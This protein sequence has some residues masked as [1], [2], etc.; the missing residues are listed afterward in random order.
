M[1][2]H[3]PP[4]VTAKQPRILVVRN[5]KIGDFMLAWPTLALLR[6]SLPQAHISVLVPAYTQA[7]AQQCPWVD[8][9]LSDPDDLGHINRHNFDAMLTLFSTARTGWAGLRGR[10]PVRVAPAT[11][12]FQFLHNRRLV[13]RRS[14]SLKPEYE[15]NLDLARH[16]LAL[17]GVQPAD[18]PPPFW[19]VS[20]AV[21]E[22]CRQRLI[23]GLGLPADVPWLF[24]HAGSGGSAVNLD[25]SQYE[26]LIRTISQIWPDDDAPA[27]VL[28]AGPG[29]QAL[30]RQIQAKL[31]GTVDQ[32]YCYDTAQGLGDFALSLSAADLFIAGSTGPLHIAAAQ[33]VLTAG[34]FP[35]RRSATA[36]RWQPCSSPDRT[37]AFSPDRATQAAQAQRLDIDPVAAGHDIVRW[38][39]QHDGIFVSKKH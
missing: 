9:I 34:F 15:Y 31:Q 25:A 8:H 30:A 24:V 2:V 23:T 6:R 10:I 38:L 7:L 20:S 26:T 13:Q 36:L 27:W 11:K 39:T 14:R 4:A 33:N 21:K 35:A 32:V 16:L 17:L 29:E 12:W 19:P 37:L 22:Q 28:T 18:N 3:A 5:D 1:T